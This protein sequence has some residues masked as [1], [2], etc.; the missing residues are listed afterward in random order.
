MDSSLGWRERK[1]Q[2]TRWAIQEHALRLFQEKGYDQ[3]TVDQI[4][5]AAEISPSTFFRYFK[6]KEDVVVQDEYDPMML[7]ALANMPMDMSPVA[8]F[9]KVLSD[10]YAQ[11]GADELDKIRQRTRLMVEVPA[12]RMRMMDG[13]SDSMDTIAEGFAR[14]YGKDAE[15]PAVRVFA[16]ALFGTMLVVMLDW[17]KRGEPEDTWFTH[18]D[19]AL[20]VLECGFQLGK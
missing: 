17:Y 15:D 18:V 20:E 4:A 9:R 8:A 3:T 6:T 14:R 1:K 16:G 11:M 10:T 12:L 2:K 13:L 5:E 7:E 19:Q